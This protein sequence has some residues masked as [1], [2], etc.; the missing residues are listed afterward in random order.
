MM[1]AID[2]YLALRRGAGFVLSNAQYLL[3]SFAAFAADRRQ[4]H[5]RTATVIEWASRAPS[6]GQRHTR[7]QTVRQFA[8]HLQLEDPRH[9]LP[10]PNHFHSGKTRRVPRIYTTAEIDRLVLAATQLSAGDALRPHTYATLIGL[11]AATGLRIS[12][13][14]HLRHGDVTSDGLLIRKTKFQKTRLVPL[15][16]TAVAGLGRY[17]AQRR[18]VHLATDH[19]FVDNNGQPLGY[20]TVYRVFGRLAEQA[21]VAPLRGHRPRLHELR[22]TFALRALQ[23]TPAGRQRIGQHMLA[24]ATYLGHVSIDSTYWYLESTPE[25]LADIAAAG[26][27]YLGGGHS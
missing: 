24:L 27:A 20:G 22:H 3:R 2:R 10:P 15:H 18:A 13:A 8:Q 6:S 5:I 1:A 25:L 9:E 21:G 4:R 23:S 26:E 12:E 11:L 19:V 17:L 14:L 7:Y 16:E